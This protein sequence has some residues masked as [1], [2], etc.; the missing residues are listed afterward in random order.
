MNRV[1]GPRLYDEYLMKQ[2]GEIVDS[3]LCKFCSV[4]SFEVQICV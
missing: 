1:R 2:R 3:V 4:M